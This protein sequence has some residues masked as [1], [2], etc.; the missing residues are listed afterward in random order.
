LQDKLDR[1][2]DNFYIA[3]NVDP[4]MAEGQVR[5]LSNLAGDIVIQERKL[6]R[7]YRETLS[8]LSTTDS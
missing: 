6:I 7:Q 1:I 4:Q 5:A 3:S 2:S 8:R